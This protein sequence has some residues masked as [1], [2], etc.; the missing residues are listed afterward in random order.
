MGKDNKKIKK[1]AFDKW[2]KD[3]GEDYFCYECNGYEIGAEE[4][5]IGALKWVLENGLCEQPT[6]SMIEEELRNFG[7]RL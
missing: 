3:N 4:G 7:E 2:W 1:A 5:W 6:A